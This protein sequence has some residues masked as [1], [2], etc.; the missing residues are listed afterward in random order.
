MRVGMADLGLEALVVLY[1]EARRYPLAKEVEA[2]PAGSG[3]ELVC[4][5][6]RGAQGWRRRRLGWDVKRL[7]RSLPS[8]RPGKRPGVPNAV[9]PRS[10]GLSG[11][12]TGLM[13]I[14]R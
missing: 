13:R 6:T 2:V 11:I 8:G 3:A 10:A 12:K 7:T 4:V 5:T 9:G 14:D 1:P